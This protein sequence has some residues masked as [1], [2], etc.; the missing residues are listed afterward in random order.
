VEQG[1]EF[2][3]LRNKKLKGLILRHYSPILREEN[4]PELNNHPV[5]CN[6]SENSNHRG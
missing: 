2:N 3:I 5:M 4:T 1:I 6:P